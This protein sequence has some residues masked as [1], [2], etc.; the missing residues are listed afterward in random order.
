MP[1]RRQHHYYLLALEPDR[2]RRRRRVFRRERHGDQAVCVLLAERWIT[3]LGRR[4]NFRANSN[5]ITIVNAGSGDAGTYSVIVSNAAGT[6][7]SANYLT[8]ILT[9]NDPPVGLVYAEVFRMLGQARVGS[10]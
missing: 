4:Q 5:V 6:D 7:S 2:L 8:T 10:R 3:T 1:W 9:V